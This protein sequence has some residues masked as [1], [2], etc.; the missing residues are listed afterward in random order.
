[1]TIETLEKV[2]TKTVALWASPRCVST[3]FE[4]T[5]SQRS[6]TGIVHEPFCD[7]YYFSQWRISDRFGDCK[8]L[9]Q[10]IVPSI[11]RLGSW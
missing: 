6:D 5:F 3:A 7:V 9:L 8:E 2:K 4:K 11:S 1:M 10:V